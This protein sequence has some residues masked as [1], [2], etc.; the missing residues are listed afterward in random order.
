ML[1]CPFVLELKCIIYP[2]L[3]G[4]YDKALDLYSKAIELNPYVAAYFGNRSFCNIKMDFF[5]AALED[6]S[7]AIKLDKK[8]IKVFFYNCVKY[9]FN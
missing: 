8:Y 1:D 6:A 3:A 5:G 7:S 9:I 2:F 4:K